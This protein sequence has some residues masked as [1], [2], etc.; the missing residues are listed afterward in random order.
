MLIDCSCVQTCP[1]CKSEWGDLIGHIKANHKGKAWKGIRTICPIE[2]CGKHVVDIKN[3][4]RLRMFQDHYHISACINHKNKIKHNKLFCYFYV[5]K[6]VNLFL[7]VTSNEIYVCLLGCPVFGVIS[8]NFCSH[9]NSGA[10]SQ[11]FSTISQ[12]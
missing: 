8:P 10:H 2:K 7:G 11:N 6:F 1:Y 5:D 12:F 3:H 4:I 9:L